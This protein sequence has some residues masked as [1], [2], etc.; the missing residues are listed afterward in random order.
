VVIKWVW[1]IKHKSYADW[2]RSQTW[3]R[4]ES[5]IGLSG[6]KQAGGLERLTFNFDCDFT[7]LLYPVTKVSGVHEYKMTI[8]STLL[9]E[10]QA[11]IEISSE[12][13]LSGYSHC[14]IWEVGPLLDSLHS[15]DHFLSC[16]SCFSNDDLSEKVFHYILLMRW[17]VSRVNL[18]LREL[19]CTDFAGIRFLEPSSPKEK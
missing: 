4:F 6:Y 15:V 19:Y 9:Q 2:Q 3:Q 18:S 12:T 11:A 10:V 8:L 5:L 14:W 7:L 16:K 17:L 13:I 1:K